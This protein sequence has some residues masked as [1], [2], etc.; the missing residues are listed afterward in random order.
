ML[1]RIPVFAALLVPVFMLAQVTVNVQLPPGGMVQKDQLWNLV[2]VNNSAGT[3]VMV[4]LDIQDAVS[5]Q[6]VLSARSRSFVLG[7]GLK[8]VNIQE[9]QPV[10]Y[11][12][13]AA[14]L[15]GSY[16]PLGSYV[17]CYRVFRNDVKGADPLGDECVRINISPLSP[18]LLN[19]PADRSEL[20]GG[21]P[22]FSW[23]PPSPM[24]MFSNLR[25]ELLVA[26][27][28]PGQS[29][30]EAILYNVPVYANHNLQTPYE[31]YPASFSKL[32]PGQQYAWQVTARN[33]L[34]YAA[35][36]TAWTFFIKP[37]DSL[38]ENKIPGSYLILKKGEEGSGTSYISTDV[39]AV[40]YYSFDATHET[41]LRF[42]TEDGKL[43][44]EVKQKAGYGDNIFQ[45]RLGHEFKKETVYIIEIK[46]QQKNNYSS[47]FILQ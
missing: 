14:E 41:V 2:L 16:L 39:L 6:P 15:S 46:D 44:K 17:A 7:K 19:T 42:L 12:H 47:R 25:Y 28:L 5:G 43:L 36:T 11:N 13:I 4:A 21:Y 35:Q 40:R 8:V 27:V 10:Q 32:K 38:Q 23:L 3:D 33:G 26:E 24:D 31:N 37:Q 22:L 34:N 29:A 1:K 30:A 18:P 45:F 20:P 9:V